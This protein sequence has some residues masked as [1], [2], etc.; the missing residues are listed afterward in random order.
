MIYQFEHEEIKSCA[1]CDL[2]K[3]IHVCSLTY[4]EIKWEHYTQNRPSWCPLVEVKGETDGNK[5]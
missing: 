5:S 1:F 3:T 2:A 4:R